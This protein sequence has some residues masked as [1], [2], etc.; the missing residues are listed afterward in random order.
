MSEDAPTHSQIV[1]SISEGAEKVR[2]AAESL[3]ERVAIF[4]NWLGTLR[5][6]VFTAHLLSEDENNPERGFFL[7]YQRDGKDWSLYFATAHDGDEGYSNLR[8]VRDASIEDKV[9]AIRAFPELLKS[10]VQ[11]QEYRVKMANAAASEFD[12]FASEIGIPPPMDEEVKT[13]AEMAAAF[14]EYS[15][16]QAERDAKKGGK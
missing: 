1:G 3:A 11:S 9:M 5:G 6:K 13:R 7:L 16:K 15:K 10:M 14:A 12:R 2:Q 4:E 8:L